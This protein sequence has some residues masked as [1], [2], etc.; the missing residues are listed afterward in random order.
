M[1]DAGRT[2]GGYNLSAGLN[3]ICHLLP[4]NLYGQIIVTHGKESAPA[5][6]AIGVL[7]FNEFNTRKRLQYLPGSFANLHPSAQMTGIVI[8]DTQWRCVGLMALIFT[9]EIP[10]RKEFLQINDFFGQV[11]GILTLVEFRIEFFK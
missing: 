4:P 9:K 7:H 3:D 11:P 6:A 1:E 10:G 5:A 2:G 8:G